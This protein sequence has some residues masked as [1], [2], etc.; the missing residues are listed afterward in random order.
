VQFTTGAGDA[1]TPDKRM[2]AAVL[3]SIESVEPPVT[4]RR[5]HAQHL[6]TDGAYSKPPTNLVHNRLGQQL[7]S[8][9]IIL[10][11]RNFQRLGCL[12]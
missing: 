5:P 9:M 6:D 4:I 2:T 1:S 7:D 10:A 12:K 3:L 8:R 11:E